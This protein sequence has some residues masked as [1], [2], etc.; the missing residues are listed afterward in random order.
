MCIR[1]SINT[2]TEDFSVNQMNVGTGKFFNCA[3]GYPT[4][5]QLIC[6]NDSSVMYLENNTIWNASSEFTHYQKTD[7]FTTTNSIYYANSYYGIG[8]YD[9]SQCDAQNNK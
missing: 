2:E 5:Q 7:L 8:Q 3:T 4:N 9:F 1:D 6:A